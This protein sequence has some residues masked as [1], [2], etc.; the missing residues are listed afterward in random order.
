M[1]QPE[2]TA[3]KPT[4]YG[5]RCLRCGAMNAAGNQTCG[6]CAPALFGS[7][8]DDPAPLPP[9]EA[10]LLSELPI[11]PTTREVAN[12]AV[13]RCLER[14]GLVVVERHKMDTIAI[15]PTWFAG[16]LP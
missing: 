1:P 3:G 2:T 6:G 16:R 11:W 9:E 8:P 5:W 7:L 13:C 4:K 10:A 12:E 15:R 14:R